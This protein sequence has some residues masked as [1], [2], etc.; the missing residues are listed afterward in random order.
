[1]KTTSKA[2]NAVLKPLGMEIVRGEG[3]YYFLSLDGEDNHPI[4]WGIEQGVYGGA[5]RITDQTVEAW[6]KDG[7]DK[8]E[9]A[10]EWRGRSGEFKAWMAARGYTKNPARRAR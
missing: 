8:I 6:V 4:N 1:M 10:F 5:P 9:E 2:V 3:Y 7:I